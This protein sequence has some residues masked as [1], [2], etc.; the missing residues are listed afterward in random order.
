MLFLDFI[1][2][3]A[4]IDIMSS[5]DY[6]A[7]LVTVNWGAV[8]FYL[9][10]FNGIIVGCYMGIKKEP[11]SVY[12]KPTPTSKTLPLTRTK[13]TAPSIKT[14]MF[15]AYC[16]KQIPVHADFCPSCGKEQPPRETFCVKC[17]TKLPPDSLFCAN[18]GAKV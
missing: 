1:V 2:V 14:K 17:G 10:L 4:V 8:F 7:G 13:P 9:F 6:E 3:V 16:G 11:T 18:C 5:A 15:C 12:I